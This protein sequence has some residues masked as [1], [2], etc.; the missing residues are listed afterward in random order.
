MQALQGLIVKGNNI[1]FCTRKQNTMMSK[2][3]K[4]ALG[5]FAFISVIIA[6]WF[7][8]FKNA[9]MAIGIGTLTIG[10]PLL[11]LYIKDK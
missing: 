2:K 3:E 5:I 7:I 1:Y 4:I 11:I 6:L 8:D 9:L 10:L